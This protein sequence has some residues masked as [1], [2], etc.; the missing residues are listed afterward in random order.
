MNNIITFED[1]QH[2]LV[3][4]NVI[5]ITP[6]L[7]NEKYLLHRDSILSRWRYISTLYWYGR[8]DPHVSPSL[9]ASLC[10]LNL[11]NGD[12]SSHKDNYAFF[13]QMKWFE[14]T[15]DKE[16]FT[17]EQILRGR[18]WQTF[19]ALIRE[20]ECCKIIFENWPKVKIT[21]NFYMDLEN[22][23][24]LIINDN[25]YLGIT[26]QGEKSDEV[27]NKRKNKKIIKGTIFFRAPRG[28]DGVSYDGI[29]FVPVNDLT[30]ALKP[31]LG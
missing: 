21:K 12:I 26:H 8:A 29:D 25:I 31:L 27:N 14:I 22:N 13:L 1:F 17:Y 15:G 3:K 24:D 10:Y 4:N 9:I 5:E 30:K 19:A 28:G 6:Q 16:G 20:L 18:I 7:L 11:F 2:W 23:V